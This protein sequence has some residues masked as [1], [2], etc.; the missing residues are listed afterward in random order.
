VED[1]VMPP[2]GRDWDEQARSWIA[3]A[4]KPGHDSYWGYRAGFLEL[5]PAPGRATLDLGCGEGRV[6]RD[7]AAQGHRVTGIDASPTML[8]A[9]RQADPAG[10]YTLADA[11]SLPFPDA[12]F[13]VVVAYNSLMDVDDMAAAVAQ[14]ARVLE[15]GGRLVLAV[16]H[17]ATN[18][19]RFEGAE[20]G[21][22]YFDRTRF[23]DEVERDGMHMLFRGWQYPLGAYTLAMEQAGLLIEALR[24]PVSIRKDGTAD[25]VPWHLWIRAL[26]P[27]GGVT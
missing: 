2:S 5:V 3:W 21:A 17:P 16:T 7:L 25:S 9:A 22:T 13:D 20:P 18:P 12:S 15:P 10:Q 27:G 26:R 19:R 14:A 11:A 23:S 4:R 6:A 8:A 24:E 1:I